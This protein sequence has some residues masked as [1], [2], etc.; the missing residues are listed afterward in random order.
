MAFDL[1][2]TIRWTP[3]RGFFLLDRHLTRIAGSARHFG[4][5]CDPADLRAALDRA[6]AASTD[7]LRVRLLLAQDGTAPGRV[8]RSRSGGRPGARPLRGCANRRRRH[9]PLSQDNKPA[10]VRRGEAPGCR[11]RDP[12]ECR[13][14]GHGDDH[15][16]RR[17]G[18]RRTEADASGRMRPAARYVSVAVAGRRRHR[19]SRH[20]H[21]SDPGSH[22]A[23]GSS[24]R[25]ASG[26]PREL[27][28]QTGGDDREHADQR[29]HQDSRSRRSA[30]SAETARP[31]PAA[32]PSARR[33]SASRAP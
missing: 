4:Y 20:H 27:G 7:T 33:W 18:N 15:R 14:P 28:P 23:C 9:L 1:L 8:R 12:V 22:R 26:G 16:E 32:R 11:R 17:R 13:S 2:E 29:Q 30:A 10:G 3:G 6:V 25:S 21:R 31:R 5:T 19:R 24:T